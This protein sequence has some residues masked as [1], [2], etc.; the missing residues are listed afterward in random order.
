VRDV[1]SER[2]IDHGEWIEHIVRY[3]DGG[4]LTYAKYK[5][6]LPAVEL[7][8]SQPMPGSH[9]AAAWFKAGREDEYIDGMKC[10]FGG[11]W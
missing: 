6:A 11:E 2:Q 10:R 5:Q 8:P 7:P 9:H 4:G 3:T 1:E